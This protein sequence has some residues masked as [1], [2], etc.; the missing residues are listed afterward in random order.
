MRTN[1]LYSYAEN[2]EAPDV[3]RDNS[4]W[5]QSVL[6]SLANRFGIEG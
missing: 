1:N 3:V 6:E 4:R 2:I 5:K